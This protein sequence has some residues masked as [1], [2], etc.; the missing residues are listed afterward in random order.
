MFAAIR[1]LKLPLGH[2]AITGSGALG[3][4][5]LREIA[6]IDIIVSA[7]L[8]DVLA[9]EYGITEDDVTLKIVIKNGV[10]EAFCEDSFF[11]QKKEPQDPNVQERI[12]QAEI[13]DGLPFEALNHIIYYKRKMGREK[14][15]EDISLLEGWIKEQKE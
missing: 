5:N 11:I 6:D 2:Y 13:I 10:I 4:R 7:E 3:I 8:W 12:A 14:D 1:E 15:L 9:K